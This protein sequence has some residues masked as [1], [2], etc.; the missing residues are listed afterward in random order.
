LLA[1]LAYNAVARSFLPTFPT[2]SI[3]ELVSATLIAAA[4]FEAVTLLFRFGLGLQSTRDTRWLR[5]WTGGLRIHH[6]YVGAAALPASLLAPV[7]PLIADAGVVVAGALIVSDL[8]HHFLV[9]WPLTGSPQFDLTYG[10]D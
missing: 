5:R 1:A 6:G 2:M 3:P 8:V 10:E 9:L 4:A 7:P